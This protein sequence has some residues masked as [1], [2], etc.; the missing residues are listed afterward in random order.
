MTK[1]EK[2]LLN[3]TNK[4]MFLICIKFFQTDEYK[5]FEINLQEI[6]CAGI[7][8][9]LINRRQ[10][11]RGGHR[12]YSEHRKQN[13]ESHSVVAKCRTGRGTVYFSVIPTL[14]CCCTV[15]CLTN[16]ALYDCI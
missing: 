12:L 5:L 3:V 11:W 7:R 14:P 10:Y 6:V 16:C 15:V 4:T 1:L 2:M 8:M 9:T 13:S